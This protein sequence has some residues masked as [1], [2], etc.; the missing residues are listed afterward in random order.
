[1]ARTHNITRRHQTKEGKNRR[2]QQIE[3]P[4]KH[5]NI[6]ILSRC[7]TIF[8]KVHTQPFRKKAD[9]E[10]TTQEKNKMGLDDGPKYGF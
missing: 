3:T 2:N 7:H 10:T 5:Q 4:H 1:M 6:K 9:N 8:R